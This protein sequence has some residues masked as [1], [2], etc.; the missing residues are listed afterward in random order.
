MGKV[1]KK[2]ILLAIAGGIVYGLLAYHIVFYGTQMAVLPKANLNFD[3]TFV[4]VNPTEF[5]T[6]TKILSDDTLREAGI[7]EVMVDFGI[8]TAEKRRTLEEKIRQEKYQ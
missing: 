4:N 3:W 5:R 7:G 8:I 1:I 2:L 6:P